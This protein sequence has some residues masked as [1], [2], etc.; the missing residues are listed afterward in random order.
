MILLQSDF[1]SQLRPTRYVVSVSGGLGS[2]EA[3]ERTIERRG[4]ENVVAVHADVGFVERDGKRVAGEDEDLIRFMSECEAYLGCQIIRIQHPKYK[5]IW[6]AFFGERFLG[7]SMIDPCSK[8]L[9]RELIERWMKENEPHGVRVIGFSWLEQSRAAKYR[10]YFPVSYFPNCD[11]P[12]LVNDEIA[13]KWEAR[14]VR[15]SM[16]YD[17]GFKHDNCGG[18][19]VKGGLGQLH[20]LWR[21]KLAWYLFAESEE[22]R[23]RAEINPTVTIFRKGGQPITMQALRVLFEAGYVPKTANQ[24]GCGGRCM[25]PEEITS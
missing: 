5:S 23:F 2:I 6:D 12:Y 9:K 1:L 14:G 21:I 22:L 10:E 11:R 16:S 20:D 25:M 4:R 17:R 3:W 8:F 19:C 15:R 24:Q 13:A 7:N 18:F